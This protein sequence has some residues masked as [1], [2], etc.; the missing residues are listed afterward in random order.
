MKRDIIITFIYFLCIVPVF[1]SNTQHEKRQVLFSSVNGHLITPEKSFRQSMHI[2]E[3]KFAVHRWLRVVGELKFPE[4]FSD[5][6]ETLFRKSESRI[7]DSLD[8]LIVKKEKYSLFFNGSGEFNDCWASYRIPYTKWHRNDLTIKLPVVRKNNLVLEKGGFFGLEV[9]LYYKKKGRNPL[10]IYDAPDSIVKLSVPSGTSYKYADLCKKINVSDQVACVL[11]KVGGYGFKGEC[12][13]ESPQLLQDNKKI[14][15]IPFLPYGEVNDKK[16]CWVGCNLSIRSWPKWKL[17]YNDSIFF[18]GEIFDRASNVSDFYIA[19]PDVNAGSGILELS[20]LKKGNGLSFP[21][22]L[23]SLELIEESARD[24]EI[25]SIPKFVQERSNFGILVEIN[26]PAQRLH[27]DC[28]NNTALTPKSQELFFEEKGL[29]VIPLFANHWATNIKISVSNGLEQRTII[30]PQIVCRGYKQIYLSSGDEIYVPKEQLLYDYFF[31]WYVRNR[32]GNWYQFRPSYQWSGCRKADPQFIRRYVALLQQL[33]MPYA[34]QVE[35]R[36]LAGSQ[37]NPSMEVLETSLFRGKQSHE[38]DGAYNYWQ[39]FVDEGLYS[40]LAAK[41]RPFG[42]IFAKQRPIYTSK[43]MFI[44]YDPYKVKDMADGARYLV[45]NLQY[46][47]GESIRHTGPSTLF[48]YLYQAGY[49]WLGAEQMYG[50]EETVMSALR[51][52]SRAY[53]RSLYGTLH[54]MQWGSKPFTDPKHAIRHYLSM[55]IAYMHGSSHINTEEGL[56]VD[57][58]ANDRYS[59]SG[60]QHLYGQNRILDFIETHTRRGELL[61]HIAVLQGRNDAWS[62]LNRNSLWAQKG[63]KWQFNQALESFDLIKVFYPNNYMGWTLPENL[64]TSTPYGTIDI[65]PIEASLNCL[66]KYKI[67]LFL[68][69]NT[70][71]DNDFMHLREF[72]KQGGILVLTS[73][74]LNSE[75]QPNRPIQFPENDSL[76]RELLG[77]QYKTYVGKKIIPFGEGKIIYF[78]QKEYPASPSICQEYSECI[79]LLAKNEIDK[80]LLKK[81]WIKDINQ[82]S[83]TVWDYDDRRTYYLLNIDWKNYSE[84]KNVVWSCNGF[85]FNIPVRPYFIETICQCEKLAIVPSSNT[86]DILEMKK[87]GDKWKVTIQTTEPEKL[88]VLN[89]ETGNIQY[90]KINQAGIHC[91]YL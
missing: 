4:E 5:R 76:I 40:D 34:W 62:L 53:N 77:E 60:R 39:H 24:F 89:A 38:N 63:K 74:H 71:N 83:Y 91:V 32:V 33:N 31:K 7:D 9:N 48:R 79:R 82:V 56:W 46:S 16:N 78:P 17:I 50:P 10:D 59:E 75:L 6:G 27:V 70:Y 57:E 72:V 55:G 37:I 69:W 80:E 61:S 29:Y 81:G 47:K 44:H 87:N 3:S 21:Y 84:N 45:D 42:G 13:L 23:R 73:A 15:D 51:G 20:L 58:Y 65:L 41:A 66:K 67:A 35:G 8:S 36:T 54:A 12:W 90:C 22:N 30:I 52:A 85:D 49:E 88:T 14:I 11:L 43:G 86:T 25:V 64:F 19:L 1:S 18:E 28:F 26:K 68:G 2:E